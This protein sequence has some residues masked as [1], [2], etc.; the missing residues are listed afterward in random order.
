M[1][2]C[3][4]LLQLVAHCQVCGTAL[5]GL[6]Q[7]RI[8]GVGESTGEFRGGAHGTSKVLAGSLWKET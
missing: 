2:L 4:P 8:R 7:G 6:H 1:E 3:W 5:D